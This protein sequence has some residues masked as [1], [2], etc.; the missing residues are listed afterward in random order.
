MERIL[1]K[2]EEHPQ[3]IFD[4]G[5]WADNKK[6]QGTILCIRRGAWQHEMK[7]MS[8]YGVQLRRGRHKITSKTNSVYP[9]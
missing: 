7:G 9:F 6:S 4:A 5:R 3:E 1:R 2:V 8:L